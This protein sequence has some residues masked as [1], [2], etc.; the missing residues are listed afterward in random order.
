MNETAKS[1]VKSGGTILV[2]LKRRA[3]GERA[4]VFAVLASFTIAAGILFY[5]VDR[6]LDPDL[7]KNWWALSFE[8]RDPN[9]SDFTVENHSS[10]T[11]FTYTV[12]RDGSTL[13]TGELSIGKG[14]RKTVSPTVPT[15][16]GRTTVSVSADDGSK[17]EIYRER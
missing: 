14:M 8:T 10:A 11:R 2:T 5:H 12:S 15:D 1:T 9:S 13:R 3:S 7:D 4:S 6:G 16:P 17:K